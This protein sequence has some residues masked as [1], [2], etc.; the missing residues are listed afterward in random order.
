MIVYVESNFVLELALL[1]EEH[2]SALTI[3][4][5]AESGRINLLMPAFCGGEPY[6]RMVR[7]AK[8]RKALR[9]RLAQE[10]RELSRSQPYI[11][12]SSLSRDLASILTKS[13]YE[14]K[15]RLDAALARI[16]KAAEIIP[17]DGP[18]LGNALG[19][20]VSLG[21]SPQDA[22][23]FASVSANMNSSSASEQ[24]VFITRDSK[25]LLTPDIEDILDQ[26]NCKLLTRFSDGLGY[27]ESMIN[28][29]SKPGNAS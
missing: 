10:V 7:R 5:H 12:V 9:E 15:D 22:I 21:L 8:D 26:Y 11:D 29:P 28:P 6:E 13:A 16:I 24:K 25:D 14:E 2:K 17:L 4:E 20:Q 3:L 18:I 1:Q 23:V 27:I 19:L